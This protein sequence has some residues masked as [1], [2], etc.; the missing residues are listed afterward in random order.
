[1][2]VAEVKN[3]VLV[4]L[5]RFFLVQARKTLWRHGLSVQA[6]LSYVL[7]LLGRGDPRID[8]FVAEAKRSKTEEQKINLVHTDDESLYHL[9]EQKL[10]DSKMS[11]EKLS[12]LEE[13]EHVEKFPKNNWRNS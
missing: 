2:I 13:D 6:F 4:S 1:M 9:I 10:L 3:K 8:V 7:E 5:N 12:E 11:R